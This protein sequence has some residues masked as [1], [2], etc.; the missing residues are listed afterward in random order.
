MS[1]PAVLYDHVPVE[2]LHRDGDTQNET[3]GESFYVSSMVHRTSAPRKQDDDGGIGDKNSKQ[4]EQSRSIENGKGSNKSEDGVSTN[5]YGENEYDNDTEVIDIEN[6][7]I[8]D[9]PMETIIEDIDSYYVLIPIPPPTISG[10]HDHD[11]TLSTGT[12]HRTTSRIGNTIRAYGKALFRAATRSPESNQD[13]TTSFWKD[14]DAVAKCLSGC[15]SGTRAILKPLQFYATDLISSSY[16]I[17]SSYDWVSETVIDGSGN[18]LIL[19]GSCVALDSDDSLNRT[20]NDGWREHSGDNYDAG[21]LIVPPGLDSVGLKGSIKSSGGIPVASLSSSSSLWWTSNTIMVSA[22]DLL[23]V[24]HDQCKQLGDRDGPRPLSLL[25]AIE[26]E[27]KEKSDYNRYYYGDDEDNMDRSTII[28][29]TTQ[30]VAH[31]WTRAL[32]KLAQH[33][34]NVWYKISCSYLRRSIRNAGRLFIIYSQQ[35]LIR[36]YKSNRRSCPSLSISS[37]D[38]GLANSEANTYNINHYVNRGGEHD[39]SRSMI[40]SEQPQKLS[41]RSYDDNQS[42]D[43]KINGCEVTARS[44]EYRFIIEMASPMSRSQN[45]YSAR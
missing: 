27:E 8:D 13:R 43:K 3:G 4:F 1:I 26:E 21:V 17:Y 33:K 20:T 42:S 37:S 9:R 34:A 32:Y 30:T 35:F 2:D 18:R 6:D 24:K 40:L 12:S 19:P 11:N 7:E 31:Q 5:K 10:D 14:N 44:S 15:A 25:D 45:G 29:A 36:Y 22:H 28:V 39:T 16:S 41:D 23:A 38:D